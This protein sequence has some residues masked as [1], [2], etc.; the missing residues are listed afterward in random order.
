MRVASGTRLPFAKGEDLTRIL[1]ADDH[2]IVVA[3]IKALLTGSDYDVVSVVSD[4]AAVLEELP[5]IR[6]D[7]LL[8]DVEMPQRSGL[9]VLRV[10]RMRGDMRPI[11][12]LT[13]SIKS[14]AAIEA[15][16]LGVN[17]V[18]LKDTAAES[19][20]KCLDA[21]KA[22][23]RWI[24]QSVLQHALTAA[25]GDG[26]GATGPFAT[27]SKKERAVVGLIGQ[28][29]RNK[30]IAAEL[31]VTEGTVKVHLHKIFEKVDVTS[32]FELALLAKEHEV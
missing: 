31:G 17:G 19:L 9:E 14:A 18:V 21:V 26:E 20:L 6:P 16:Q 30:E 4:G 15:V 8:L 27:L 5:K 22:G 11:V 24:D 25:L 3:G 23:G 28:G 32:R 1:I 13:G 29:L 12:L 7:L 2:P 10:L